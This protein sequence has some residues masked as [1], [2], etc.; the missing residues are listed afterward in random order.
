VRDS[1]L[2][3]SSDMVVLLERGSVVFKSAAWCR[4]P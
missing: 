2:I 3:S 1:A 4:R